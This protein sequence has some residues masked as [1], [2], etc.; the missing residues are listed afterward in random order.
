MAVPKA[1]SDLV[2]PMTYQSFFQVGD[3]VRMIGSDVDMTVHAVD[4]E[5]VLVSWFD[6]NKTLQQAG[7]KSKMLMK[8]RTA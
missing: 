7:F 8:R 3:V 1:Y 4:N 6:A 5:D 2:L